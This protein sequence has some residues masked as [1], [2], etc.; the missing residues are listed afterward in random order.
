MPSF[1]NVPVYLEGGGM[2][3]RGLCARVRCVCIC[4]CT[5]G[6]IQFSYL[7]VGNLIKIYNNS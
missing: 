2:N 3:Y 1:S 4:M 7:V 5:V 6:T